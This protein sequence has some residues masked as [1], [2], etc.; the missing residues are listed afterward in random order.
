MEIFQNLEQPHNPCDKLKIQQRHLQHRLLP[1][2][3]ACPAAAIN[4]SL[5]VAGILAKILQQKNQ[6]VCETSGKDVKGCG[7]W[8]R[9]DRL[10]ELS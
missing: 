2:R 7:L 9:S 10:H 5:L 4:L 1:N 3:K 6:T 8:V